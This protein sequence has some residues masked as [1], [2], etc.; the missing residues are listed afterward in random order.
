M[1][2]E[3]DSIC[4]VLKPA[5]MLSVPGKSGR[6]SVW[7]VMRE[8]MPEAEGPI[9]VHRL[10]MDTSGLMVLAKTWVA[11]RALQRQFLRHEV[12]KLYVALLTR[13]VEGTEGDIALP[14]RPD[15]HDRPRQVVDAVH[16]KRAETHWQRLGQRLIALYPHTGRTHQLRV[17]CAHAEGLNNPILGD[18]LYGQRADRLYLHAKEIVFRHPV[19]GIEMKFENKP[20][21]E[22]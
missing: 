21:W 13:D 5:G 2:F 6:E 4:V 17:H 14:L 9:V 15:L 19:T 18:P 7:S 10:D 20:A 8:R 3:D 11:Y 16:G 1:V 22:K 12:K